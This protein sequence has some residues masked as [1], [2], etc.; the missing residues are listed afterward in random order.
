M[1]DDPSIA[2]DLREICDNRNQ[3]GM[4]LTGYSDGG[5]YA[6]FDKA[7]DSNHQPQN[8]YFQEIQ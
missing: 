5:I 6:Y 4:K 2:E 8:L 7:I 1:N 3:C